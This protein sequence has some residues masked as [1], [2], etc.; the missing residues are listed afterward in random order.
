MAPIKTA[1]SPK[2]GDGFCHQTS[3]Y[4]SFTDACSVGLNADGVHRQD[5]TSQKKADYW[6]LQQMPVPV[7]N[8]TGKRQLN[9][10]TYYS[11]WHIKALRD[12][13]VSSRV[14]LWRGGLRTPLSASV[15]ASKC[16]GGGGGV[17]ASICVRIC[18]MQCRGVHCCHCQNALKST[19]ASII[20]L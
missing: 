5:S 13:G 15:S 16:G 12:S 9:D 7:N 1:R 6:W 3:A 20:Y 2:W 14:C 8:V 19:E 18:G 4:I 17:C 10:Q 11:S